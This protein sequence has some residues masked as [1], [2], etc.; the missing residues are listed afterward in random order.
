MVFS[1]A[2]FIKETNS[3]GFIEEVFRCFSERKLAVILK[4]NA[5]TSI[6]G[7]EA[8]EIVEPD[9]RHGWI[10][11]NHVPIYEKLPGMVVFSSGTE[12]A[13]KAIL[14]SHYALANTVY[15]LNR[16]MQVD[17]SIREYVG[18][19]V[20]YS[21]G[22]GRIRAICSAG[23]RAYLPESGFNPYEIREMLKLGEIN[24]ISAVPT[25]WRMVLE[26]QQIIGKYGQR[27][28]WIEIGSQ[29][30]SAH[31]KQLMKKLFPN[32]VIVQHYGLTE[33]SRSTFI[34]IDNT[35][36]EHYESVG[37]ALEGVEVKISD[38]SKIMIRGEHI[39]DG[40]VLADG[41]KTI[42][43]DDEWFETNDLGHFQDGYL[44]YDGRADDVIN[45]GG[46]K[47]NPD[48]IQ[49]SLAREYN[50]A[51]QIVIAKCP[52]ELRGDGVLVAILKDS[53]LDRGALRDETDRLLKLR[54][55]N[56]QS[57]IH[58]FEMSNFP[59]TSTGKVQR[60]KIT[61]E[62]IREKQD[63]QPTPVITNHT[64]AE[65]FDEVAGVFGGGPIKP[66]DTFITLGGDSLNYV[67]LT[68]LLEKH[69]GHIPAN[70]ENTP[71]INLAKCKSKKQLKISSIETSTLLRVIA[72]IAVV[73]THGGFKYAGGGT[74]L[75]FVL[76]GYNMARF[77]HQDFVDGGVWRWFGPYALKI[78][79]PYLILTVL[80]FIYSNEIDFTTLLLI[81]NLVH[82]KITTVFPFWFVQVLLQ[83]LLIISLV[84]SA[85]FVRRKLQ[86]DEWM[87]SLVLLLIFTAILVVSPF[88]WDT[89]YLRNLVPQR[90]LVLLWLGYCFCLANT[91]SKRT[92]VMVIGICLAI[93]ASG[94]SIV[95]HWLIWASVFLAFVPSIKIPTFLVRSV[96]VIAASTFYIFIFNGVSL[97]FLYKVAGMDKHDAPIVVK[98]LM[99]A[100]ATIMCVAI[101]K[102]SEYMDLEKRVMYLLKWRKNTAR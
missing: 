26:N 78:L 30:M 83:C 21:F 87:F 71:F 57:S 43:D 17:E 22:F 74:L 6:P 38:S 84:L 56:A 29:Y 75:L 85:K 39:C 45:I 20:N 53:E 91:Q 66:D 54:N 58:V 63:S 60:K 35:D 16:I 24:A 32:A 49:I 46:I 62:F 11:I 64:H 93:L 68:M 14:L 76:I 23:G 59:Q 41:V 102:V 27:V 79:I 97:M 2:V 55:I 101:W 18:V 1:N 48:D 47:L 7:I 96:N 80:F 100:L 19:P 95:V 34:R 92:V 5:E 86:Q 44:Y 50:V 4:N 70:W 33:A 73:F 77:K 52:D 37:L 51:N 65:L 99:I 12:A 3:V 15:R 8:E 13:P 40:I 89:G 28:K 25:L 67:Q 69:L 98:M 61:E 82:L 42:V 31:E 88:I 10:D 72:I 9:D 94:S 90:F 36:E 81:T